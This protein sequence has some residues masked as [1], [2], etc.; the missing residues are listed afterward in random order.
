MKSIPE[1]YATH[2]AEDYRHG[3]LDC[4]DFLAYDAGLSEE[5]KSEILCAI[6]NQVIEASHRG[7][8]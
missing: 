4:V 5:T 1:K 8:V 2:P 7:A 3:F 6:A